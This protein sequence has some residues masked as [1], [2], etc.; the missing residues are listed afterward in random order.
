MSKVKRKAIQLAS[1]LA[2]V[3]TAFLLNT[4]DV[5]SQ[6]KQIRETFTSKS[7][8]EVR[9]FREDVNGVI[10]DFTIYTDHDGKPKYKEGHYNDPSDNDT[11]VAANAP[12]I[13][14]FPIKDDIVTPTV[15]T[16][17]TIVATNV[18]TAPLPLEVVITPGQG[19]LI[20]KT[21]FPV[22]TQIIDLATG[23]VVSTYVIRTSVKDSIRIPVTNLKKGTAYLILSQRGGQK[24]LNTFILNNDYS[25]TFIG[26]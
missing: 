10:Y 8:K 24:V 2:V 22:H 4:L 11:I 23:T 3:G 18:P 25:I 9:W 17:D 7:G 21:N 5:V 14:S 1:V 20:L 26:K 13:V 12:T 16:N 6:A 19:E 15:P